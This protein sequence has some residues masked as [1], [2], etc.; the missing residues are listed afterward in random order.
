M[1]SLEYTQIA[2]CRICQGTAL[3]STLD[4]GSQVLASIF[5]GPDEEDP[6]TAPLQLDRCTNCGLVQLRHSVKSENLYTYGYGYRSGINQTMTSHLGELVSWASS[7]ARLE[8]GDVVLDVG[9]ND[10][11]LL[12][13]YD[14]KGLRR[15]GIDPIANK[16]ADY[17]PDDIKTIEAF[18]NKSS[19]ND[20]LG[21]TGKPKV[22]TSIAM[23]YDLEDPNDFVNVVAETLDPNGVWI[24]EQSYLPT[25][26]ET[27]AFDTVCHEHLEYYGLKQIEDLASKHNLRVFDASLNDTNGGSFRLAVCHLS[28]DYPLESSAL[29]Q[30]RDDEHKLELGTDAPYEAFSNRISDISKNLRSLLEKIKAEGKTVYLYGASTKGNTLLQ[31]CRLDKNIVVAAAERNPEKWGTR[32]P[33][34]GIPIIS[35]EVARAANPD[36][37]LV[38]PWHFRTEFLEREAKFLANGGKFIFPLP[39]VEIVSSD[40]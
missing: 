24:L 40:S 39:E 37:F 32:T 12:K 28:A 15:F 33:L 26:L 31:Y 30:L 23:F 34:T 8:P 10:G 2:A 18:F 36:Y 7:L 35:E 5:P 4:L 17:Y 6:P 11:T 16:F 13:S 29:Q 22:I 19:C 14:V 9:C 27:N 3:V 20:I 38:L 25:M 1:N 21:S